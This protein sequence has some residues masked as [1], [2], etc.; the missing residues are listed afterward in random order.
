MKRNADK[1]YRRGA[2]VGLTTAELFMLT[3]FMLITALL[4][5]EA[6][7][8]RKAAA[9]AERPVPGVSDAVARAALEIEVDRLTS[10]SENMAKRLTDSEAQRKDT[11]GRN[12]RL[13]RALA[14]EEEKRRQAEEDAD[15]ALAAAGAARAAAETAEAAREAA[16]AHATASEAALAVAREAVEAEKAKA[17]ANDAEAETATKEASREQAQREKE[18]AK[19]IKGLMAKVADAQGRAATA[20]AALHE[21]QTAKQ[22][23]E[24]EARAAREAVD[25]ARRQTDAVRRQFAALQTPETKLI[26]RT[27]SSRQK[28]IDPPC[29]YTPVQRSDGTIREKALYLMDVAIHDRHIV[30]GRR[31]PPPGGPDDEEGSYAAEFEQMGAHRLPYGKRLTNTQA[32]RALQGIEEQGK[33]A[34]IRSYPCISYAQVWDRTGTTSKQRWRE[35]HENLVQRYLGTYVVRDMRKN[36]WPH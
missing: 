35:V 10:E 12:Q 3:S 17:Q 23:A 29:W 14:N 33:N 30:L 20:E 18:I 4:L 16:L 32:R 22:E 9:N 24:Q 7:L 15:E 26:Q 36:P 34:K 31:S 5:A 13:A 25:E 11:E 19:V 6:H 27:G 2:V 28:G 21:A 8:P 1:S